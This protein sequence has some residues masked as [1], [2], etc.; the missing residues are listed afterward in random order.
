MLIKLK[1]TQYLPLDY[2]A[3]IQNKLY[4]CSF[5]HGSIDSNDNYI[6]FD[7]NDFSDIRFEY[8]CCFLY[9]KYKEEYTAIDKTNMWNIMFPG[10]GTK[11]KFINIKNIY[12]ICG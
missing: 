11:I 10:N 3:N 5:D 4:I 8:D 2:K 6:P 1:N 7:I 12:Y 9:F